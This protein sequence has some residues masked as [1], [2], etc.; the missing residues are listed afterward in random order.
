MSASHRTHQ[1]VIA[2]LR[3][4]RSPSESGSALIE[5][6][7]LALLLLIPIV[8]LILTL[9]AVHAGKYAASSAAQSAARVFVSAPD[10]ASA[11]ARAAGAVRIALDDQ[12]FTELGAGEALEISCVPS[13]AH[14]EHHVTVRIT[15]PVRVP[16]IPFLDAGPAV[17]TVQHEQS[18]TSEQFRSPQ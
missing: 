4:R 12:G 18:A 11:H 3:A 6:L 1:R 14:P 16:G 17:F 7:V 2:K 15:I 8:Y 5:F 10:Q 13:C 9:T